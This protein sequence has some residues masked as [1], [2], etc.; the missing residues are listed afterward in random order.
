VVVAVLVEV[1]VGV[2]VFSSP[3]VVVGVETV[4][5]V[6]VVV[7]LLPRARPSC[8]DSPSPTPAATPL[9]PRASRTSNVGILSL[10]PGSPTVP[11]IR[12]RNVERRGKRI[13]PALYRHA[14]GNL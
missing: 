2:V 7:V 8:E 5:L 9:A 3:V 11:G 12:T 4:V 10:R 1:V 14:V 13:M 6:A